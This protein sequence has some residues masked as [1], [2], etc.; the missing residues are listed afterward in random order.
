VLVSGA[1]VY[2]GKGRVIEAYEPRF[3]LG[4]AFSAPDAEPGGRKA[5]MEYDAV[6]RAVRTINPDGSERRVVPGVPAV[7]SSPGAFTPTP[8]EVY[9]YDEN[10]NAGR[11]HPAALSEGW[12]AHRDTPSSVVVDALGRAVRDTVRNGPGAA[13]AFTTRRAYDIRGNVTA[14]DDELGRPVARTVY[15][16]A[17]RPLRAERM[18]A[19]VRRTVLDAA[20]R[21]V[22]LRDGRGALTLAAFDAAGRT[23]RTWARDGAEPLPTLREVTVWGDTL[24]PERAPAAANLRGRVWRQYDGAGTVTFEA[25]DF[26]GAVTGKVR[27]ALSDAEVLK[28]F[29]PRAANGYAVSPYRVD[30]EPPAGTT[31]DAHAARMLDATELR[32]TVSYDALGRVKAVTQ[33]RDAE[34]GRKVVRPR[35]DRAGRLQSVWVDGTVFVERIAYDARGLRTLIAYGN[36]VMTRYAY[37][38][39]NSRLARLLTQA[40]THPG[41]D[42][43]A[44]APRADRKVLQDLAY[45]YDLAGNVL[46]LQDR[47]PASGVAANPDA[48]RETDPVLRDLLSRGEALVRRFEYD[49]LYR[50]LSATGRECKTLPAPRPW[51]DD[52][53]CASGWSSYGVPSDDNAPKLASTWREGYAW[54]PAGNLLTFTHATPTVTWTR[55]FGMGGCTPQQW[56]QEWPARVNAPAPWTSA[57]GNRMTHAGDA[58]AS[59]PATHAYDANGNLVQETTSRLYTWDH[60]DRL[61]LFRVQAAGARPSVHAFYLYDSAGS[62]VKKVWAKQGSP[63]ESTVYLEGFERR[64]VGSHTCDTL[65]LM[66]DTRRIALVRI[67]SPL[68]GDNSP[69][70]Q[71]QLADHL[72]SSALVVDGAAGQVSREEFSPFGETLMGS[73]AKKRYR[74]TGKERDEESGLYYHGARYYAPHLARWSAADP[75]GHVDG[76]N[77]YRYCRGNPVMFVD[78]AGTNAMPNDAQQIQSLQA[79]LDKMPL[80]ISATSGLTAA[81]RKQADLSQRKEQT[82][83]QGG[84]VHPNDYLRKWNRSESPVIQYDGQLASTSMVRQAEG[85]AG[86]L[87]LG[88][89]LASSPMATSGY[90]GAPTHEEGKARARFGAAFW[91]AATAPFNPIYQGGRFQADDATPAHRGYVE[92][93]QKQ[94]PAQPTV[95]VQGSGRASAPATGP[96][97]TVRAHTPGERFFDYGDFAHQTGLPPYLQSTSPNISFNLSNLATGRRG[98]DAIPTSPAPYLI[99][100]LKPITYTQSTLLRQVES[101]GFD[102]SNTRFFFYDRQGNFYEG[103]IPTY[104]DAAGNTQVEKVG[105]S[106]RYR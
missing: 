29:D 44:F 19:G 76:M 18:D 54:D 2:D 36:G 27:R 91:D 9:T 50:L 24:P 87:Q 3:S 10:D 47:T 14:M 96:V 42:A 89:D 40:F 46:T 7:L 70:V 57:P 98:P 75:A 28:G 8:W 32:T 74:F 39:D 16:L 13:D 68:P 86:E 25:Y 95:V 77:L 48:L 99:G 43:L 59:F 84:F 45:A 4:F 12:R 55:R 52:P 53:R 62:R 85:I 21:A 58:S 20:G 106:G 80:T 88:R 60:A 100:E 83:V 69:P 30:W 23:V 41:G 105:G 103:V 66:D 72:G 65:H 22:E 71:F 92:M 37:E 81:E 17:G 67:G 5:V 90:L 56:A 97:A 31:L 15:D 104:T 82:L 93:P 64:T 102:A 1:R 35:Y 6:G 26:K 63:V 38:P 49:P 73:F 79:H 101:W 51:G 34:G 11:T 33:P 78:P 94:A 61:A